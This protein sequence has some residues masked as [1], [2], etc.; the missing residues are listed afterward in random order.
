VATPAET[1]LT[2]VAV[3]VVI[4]MGLGEMEV[5]RLFGQT[6]LALYTAL[7]L[8][9]VVLITALRGFQVVLAAGVMA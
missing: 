4:Q 5:L 3:A 2:E 9:L 7:G 6:T 8:V 1:A